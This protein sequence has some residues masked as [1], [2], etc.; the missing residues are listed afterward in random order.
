MVQHAIFVVPVAGVR[1]RR[2]LGV[3]FGNSLTGYQLNKEFKAY[4]LE[5]ALGLSPADSARLGPKCVYNQKGKAFFETFI[6]TIN[7]ED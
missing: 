1:R 7:L 6:I 2:T 4:A 5:H 3:E